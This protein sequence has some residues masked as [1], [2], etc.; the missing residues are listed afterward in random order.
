MPDPATHVL[1]PLAGIRLIEIVKRRVFISSPNR[2]IFALGCIFPDLIDKAVPYSFDYMYRYF[3]GERSYFPTLEYLHTPLILILCIYMFCFVFVAEYRKKV[4][5]F[6]SAG[7]L[8]H[9]LL[10]FI[11]GNSCSIGYLWLFPFSLEKPTVVTMFYDDMTTS[12]GPMF[13]AIFVIMEV[14]FRVRYRRK[15]FQSIAQRKGVDL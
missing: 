14:V 2:Y 1:A 5:L 9:L 8:V 6:L 7:V 15:G 4:F 11:Q 12:F 13:L 3:T 10:D